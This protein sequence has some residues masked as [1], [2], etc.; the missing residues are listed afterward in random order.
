M[1]KNGD[2]YFL[3]G[4]S[5]FG[6][7]RDGKIIEIEPYSTITKVRDTFFDKLSL[8]NMWMIDETGCEVDIGFSIIDRYFRPVSKT[9]NKDM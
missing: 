8:R 3:D 4:A 2:Q 1:V 5:Q 6:L 7:T 9:K